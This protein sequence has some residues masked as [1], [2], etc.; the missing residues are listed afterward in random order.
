MIFF[1]NTTER[2]IKHKSKRIVLK[3]LRDIKNP[4]IIRIKFF[5]VLAKSKFFIKILIKKFFFLQL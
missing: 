1:Y 2:K 3:F 4:I 5:K